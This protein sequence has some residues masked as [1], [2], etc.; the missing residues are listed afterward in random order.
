[1]SDFVEYT[2]RDSFGGGKDVFRR[3]Y[4]I[5][6]F[7]DDEH[8]EQGLDVFIKGALVNPNAS[9]WCEASARYIH[10]PLSE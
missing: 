4:R 8:G 10:G 7:P 6:T 2:L 5:A 3:G 1:M 9:I